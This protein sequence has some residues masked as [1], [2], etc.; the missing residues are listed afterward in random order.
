MKD[1]WKIIKALPLREVSGPRGF[2]KAQE[3]FSLY[4][5]ST[6]LCTE[7]IQTF[8]NSNSKIYSV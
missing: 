5:I 6:I 4:V 3:T 7:S 2:H 1:K 8:P